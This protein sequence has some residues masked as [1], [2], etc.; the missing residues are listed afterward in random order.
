M[1]PGVMTVMSTAPEPPGAVTL[2]DVAVFAVMVP[3][4]LPKLTVVA[5]VKPVPVMVTVVPAVSGPTAGEILDTTGSAVYVY[6]LPDPVADVPP[7][8]VT[9]TFTTPAVPAG[10]V[11]VIDV[12]EFVRMV[13]AVLPNFTAVGPDKPVPVMVTV[14]PAVSGPAAGEML[15]TAGTA[16]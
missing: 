6:L 7:G 5:P 2:I 13:P 14:V 12:D 9:V 15:V 11:T 16:S 1:P 10:A 8:V 4:V 3:G